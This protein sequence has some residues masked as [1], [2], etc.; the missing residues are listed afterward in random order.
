MPRKL[1]AG[2][3]PQY[4]MSRVLS[5]S[6]MKSPPLVV[7]VTGSLGGGIVSATRSGRGTARAIGAGAAGCASASRGVRAAAPASVAPVRNPRRPTTGEWRLDMG[8]SHQRMSDVGCQ[9]SDVRCRDSDLRHPTSDLCHLLAVFSLSTSVPLRLGTWP[10]GM[11]ATDAR[12]ATSI[13]ETE[14][15]V[16]LDT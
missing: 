6:T 10:T 13:A 4:S 1:E 12:R 2:L 11:V 16:E 15:S 3:M 9:M 14:L 8:A 7:C 5:T